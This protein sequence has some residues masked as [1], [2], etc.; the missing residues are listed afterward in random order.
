[1]LRVMRSTWSDCAMPTFTLSCETRETCTQ[2]GAEDLKEKLYW[3]GKWRIKCIKAS[4]LVERR[5]VWSLCTLFLI[6]RT[7]SCM[8]GL[9][10]LGSKSNER[11]YERKLRQTT[12][13]WVFFNCRQSQ[14]QVIYDLSAPSL[15]SLTLYLLLLTQQLCIK[16]GERE[17]GGHLSADHEWFF[18]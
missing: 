9:F 6:L 7:L 4:W 1:M 2:V 5:G 16:W 18:L 13:S 14:H 3:Q 11:K 8:N 17:R 12:S 10:I 15:H